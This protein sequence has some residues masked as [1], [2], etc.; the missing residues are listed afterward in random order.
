MYIV[1][2]E[3]RETYKVRAT[4]NYFEDSNERG[5]LL[6]FLSDDTNPEVVNFTRSAI[7]V[8]NKSTSLNYTLTSQLFPGHYHV[9]VYDIEQD[10]AL[11]NGV[12]YPAD[13]KDVFITRDSQG[14]VANS[15]FW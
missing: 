4:I 11:R 5:A 12:G 14:I 15:G 7:V 2:D 3:N 1:L 9:L 6:V 8:L 10:G 13:A